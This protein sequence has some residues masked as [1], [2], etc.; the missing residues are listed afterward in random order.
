MIP[1]EEEYEERLALLMLEEL[2]IHLDI[3][4]L[5]CIA[6][7]CDYDDHPSYLCEPINNCQSI[8]K[9]N[10]FPVILVLSLI[11]AFDG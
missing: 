6:K 3:L 2:I 1:Y 10:H 11:S 9:I 8:S 5:R 7:V 4:C